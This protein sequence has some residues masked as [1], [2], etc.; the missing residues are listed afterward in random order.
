MPK[1]AQVQFPALSPRAQAYREG[2]AARRVNA[3]V[4]LPQILALAKMHGREAV[5]RA[6]GNGA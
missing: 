3:R 5:V 4:H 1:C 2:L 6:N